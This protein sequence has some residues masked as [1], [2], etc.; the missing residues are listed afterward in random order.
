VQKLS[1]HE[2]LQA[3]IGNGGRAAGVKKLARS[4]EKLYRQNRGHLSYSLLCTIPGLGSAYAARIIAAFELTRRWQPSSAG[5]IY[6]QP[7]REVLTMDTTEMVATIVC[8]LYN[9]AHE[10]IDRIYVQLSPNNTP[11][12]IVRSI[13][14]HTLPTQA[15]SVQV[16]IVGE[17]AARRAFFSD[18]LFG[19]SLKATLEF[20]DVSLQRLSVVDTSGEVIEVM[21]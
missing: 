19:A 13:L 3:L 4:V 6:F 21:L 16:G 15:T 8:D 20:I 12:E 5:A 7:L 1:D 2:L 18:I 10:L 17:H 11:G 14:V 9:G